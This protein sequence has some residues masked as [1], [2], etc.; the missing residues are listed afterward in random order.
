MRDGRGGERDGVRGPQR[1]DA[2]DLCA[3]GDAREALEEAAPAVA[4]AADSPAATTVGTTALFQAAQKNAQA[5]RMRTGSR[6]R[7]KTVDVGMDAR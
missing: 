1:E 6:I 4:S 3:A 7:W 5:V 2:G